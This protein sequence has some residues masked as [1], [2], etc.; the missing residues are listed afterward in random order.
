VCILLEELKK[1]VANTISWYAVSVSEDLTR[2]AAWLG[3]RLF[4]YISVFCC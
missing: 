4:V 3:R 2:I 1:I